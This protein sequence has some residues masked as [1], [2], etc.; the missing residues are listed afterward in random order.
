MARKFL[1][2]GI[3]LGLGL[4]SIAVSSKS[5]IKNVIFICMENHSFDNMLG[6]MEAPYGTLTGE[7][8]NYRTP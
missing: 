8:Y 3:L 6:Y 7:E 4:L 1:I 2:F 5:P